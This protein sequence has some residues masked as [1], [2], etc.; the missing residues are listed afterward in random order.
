MF[1]QFYSPSIRCRV[2]KSRQ[3]RLKRQSPRIPIG[4]LKKDL[5]LGPLGCGQASLMG[6]DAGFSASYSIWVVSR[7]GVG[8]VFRN[9]RLM[10]LK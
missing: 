1:P 3:V 10:L 7:A 2:K 5:M 4:L 8:L 6:V 9:R